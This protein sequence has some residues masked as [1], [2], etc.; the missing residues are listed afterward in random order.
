LFVSRPWKN[1]REIFQ[2][3]GK[4]PPAFPSLGKIHARIFQCLEKAEFHFPI[5]GNPDSTWSL[6]W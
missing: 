6:V 3:Q 4:S 2:G 5:L 1:Y